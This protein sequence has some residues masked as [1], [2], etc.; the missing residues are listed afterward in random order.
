[1]LPEVPVAVMSISGFKGMKRESGAWSKQSV[2]LPI[3][4]FRTTTRDRAT[5]GP[6]Q[7]I[8]F[9]FDTAMDHIYVQRQCRLQVL[10]EKLQGFWQQSIHTTWNLPLKIHLL[11][12][13]MRQLDLDFRRR[14]QGPYQFSFSIILSWLI[15]RTECNQ[16]L[17]ERRTGSTWCTTSH[18]R[19]I[20]SPQNLRISLDDFQYPH[21]KPFFEDTDATGTRNPDRISP[22]S[23]KWWWRLGIAPL[24]E[25]VGDGLTVITTHPIPNKGKISFCPT[26]SLSL[27]FPHIDRIQYQFLIK[28]KRKP[29]VKRLCC[30]M[31]DS[32]LA[33][34]SNSPSLWASEPSFDG[35][36]S[37]PFMF[38]QHQTWLE[39]W[40]PVHRREW[41]LFL[42]ATSVVDRGTRLS[43]L[44]SLNWTELNM[45]A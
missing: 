45:Y 30:A 34:Y 10:A 17:L 19:R 28:K 13:L 4:G 43:F 33:W 40:S 14:I 6:V 23:L 9:S 15:V 22:F 32:W 35:N 3:N 16:H 8:K 24:Q 25:M 38:F 20:S 18:S 42:E 31:L 2:A 27:S 26:I 39:L 5:G 21:A 29:T 7:G 36:L 11:W 1:M 44:W 37:V 41:W 12:I